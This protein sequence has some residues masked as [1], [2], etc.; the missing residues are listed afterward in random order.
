[1]ATCAICGGTFGDRDVIRFAGREYC[2]R[3]KETPAFAQ[4][5]AGQDVPAPPAGPA[6][7]WPIFLAVGCLGMC[8]LTSLLG[9]VGISR[10]KKGLTTLSDD[11]CREELREFYSAAMV[12][13]AEHS[14]L[15]TGM[16]AVPRAGLE[17]EEEDANPTWSCPGALL[18]N[19][20]DDDDDELDRKLRD[21]YRGLL[22]GLG[23]DLEEPLVW[24][25][26]PGNHNGRGRNVL[27]GSGA[28]RFLPESEFQDLMRKHGR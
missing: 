14:S 17:E 12:Y 27:F 10:A 6:P 1:M 20:M 7:R 23:D 9:V 2:E 18:S 11:N 24:D 25:S 13:R 16:E 8:V 19:V 21:S 15:P 22:P 5:A 3:C 4:V 26:T 28:I